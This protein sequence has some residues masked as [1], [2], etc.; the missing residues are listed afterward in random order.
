[1]AGR[2]APALSAALAGLW[3]TSAAGGGEPVP[4]V[5]AS[6]FVSP[7]DVSHFVRQ[8]LPE[9]AVSAALAHGLRFRDRPSFGSGLTWTGGDSFVGVTD[10]GPN[11]DHPE[12]VGHDEGVLFPLPGFTPSLVRSTWSA[13]S[14]MAVSAVVALHTADGRGV[15]GLPNVAADAPGYDRRGAP[16]ALARDPGGLDVEGIARLPDGR[17]LLVDE[18]APSLIVVSADG[19]VMKRYVPPSRAAAVAGYPVEGAVPESFARRRSNRGF[20]SV[21][22]SADGRQAWTLL[23]SPLGA[24]DDPRF[25]DS[26][27]IRILEWDV[28]RSLEARPVAMYLMQLATRAEIPTAQRQ[29]DIKVSDAAWVADGRLLISER[30]PQRARLVLLD[31][32]GATDVLARPEAQDL[33]L[34]AAD[35][36]LARWGMTLAGRTVVL[37]SRDVPG[38]DRE[39]IEGVALV[40]PRDVVIADD[41][42]FAMS[43]NVAGVPAKLWRLRWTAPLTAP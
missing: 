6:T 12:A 24:R 7:L 20:E 4:A 30:G 38:V 32:R 25:G 9:D 41:N 1:M 35:A 16:M 5:V 23:E 37:D 31:L 15:S 10:R 8:P 17:F 21:A 27:T 19:E 13:G 2:R 26:R 42:D 3:L 28:S 11:D 40:G 36:P 18:Y 43:D 39:K 33:S 14:V 22:V 29:D 34:D